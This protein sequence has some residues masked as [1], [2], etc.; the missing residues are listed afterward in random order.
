MALGH[1]FVAWLAEFFPSVQGI[2]TH[3]HFNFVLFQSCLVLLCF[4]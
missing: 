3:I 1:D 4:L 2:S